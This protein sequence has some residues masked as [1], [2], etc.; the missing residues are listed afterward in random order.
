MDLP[1]RR[2]SQQ[3]VLDYLIKTTGRAQTFEPDAR[4][5]PAEVRSHVMIPKILSK[6]GMHEERLAR[7]AERAGH[8]H[9][10]LMAYEKAVRTYV[11]AQHVIFEPERFDEKRYWFDRAIACNE[12]IRALAA[13]PIERLE[14]PWNGAQ[15]PA[16]FHMEP[17]RERAPTILFIPGMDGTKETSGIGP[18]AEAFIAHGVH[19]FSMDGPGQGE[20]T[21]RGIHVG[22]DNYERAVSAALDVLLARPEVDPD[23]LAV[24]GRSFG[25][26]WAVRA[27]AHDSRIKALAVDAICFGDKRGIFEKAS[28]RFKQIFMMMA[29][30]PDEERFD[31]LAEQMVF[32]DQPERVRC[33]ALISAGEFDP[34]TTL[35][36]IED[37]FERL[38]GPKELWVLEDQFHAYRDVPGMAGID[39]L[40][41]LIDWVLDTMQ[42]PLAP[43]HRRVTLVGR[44]SAGPYDDNQLPRP[45]RDH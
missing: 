20:S 41:F 21:L 44:A 11:G 43:D 16:H 40:H 4:T 35:E 3:W 18:L 12:R 10:A 28:P 26:Y 25:S 23:R 24:I 42:Q 30:E 1:R 39:D 34:L 27:A 9:V 22:V 38:A 14:V 15:M 13:H 7:Q 33:P 2:D 32:T 29:G 37:V 5:L 17:R 36:E 31:A 6:R 19:V 8:R 45:W